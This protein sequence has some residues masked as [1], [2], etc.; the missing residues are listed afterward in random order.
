MLEPWAGKQPSA[1]PFMPAD[2]VGLFNRLLPAAVR[3]GW[4]RLTPR[5]T[6]VHNLQL[7]DGDGILLLNVGPGLHIEA[8]SCIMPVHFDGL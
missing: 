4:A 2:F 1:H 7:R 5:A 6:Q 8:D 3:A